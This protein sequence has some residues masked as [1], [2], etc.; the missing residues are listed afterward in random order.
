VEWIGDVERRIARLTPREVQVM[1]R[2]AEGCANKV[3][4]ADLCVS[5]RTVEVHHHNLMK[6][7]EL[8]TVS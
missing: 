1:D 8:S 7:L 3:I 5:L 2:V 4:A 6:K